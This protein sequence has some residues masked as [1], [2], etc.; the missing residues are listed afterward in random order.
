MAQGLALLRETTH[1]KDKVY[2]VSEYFI[3]N[4]LRNYFEEEG[5]YELA[6]PEADPIFRVCMAFLFFVW[7]LVR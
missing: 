6:E 7:L 3:K 5:Y 2:C 4:A 1:G